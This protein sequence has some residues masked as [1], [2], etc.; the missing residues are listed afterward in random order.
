MEHLF[1]LYGIFYIVRTLRYAIKNFNDRAIVDASDPEQMKGMF[2][3]DFL[4]FILDIV[5]I[6]AGAF[7]EEKIYFV[8]IIIL[9][10]FMPFITMMM[11]AEGGKASKGER[12]LN[13]I[14]MATKIFLA[15]LIVIKHFINHIA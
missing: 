5:W 11:P 9:T 7:T 8:G 10:F 3:S 1:Y 13:N 15:L 4:L 2:K 12:L 14:S 6:I